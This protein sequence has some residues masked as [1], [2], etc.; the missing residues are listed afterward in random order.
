MNSTA[1]CSTRRGVVSARLYF[2]RDSPCDENKQPHHTGSVA[3]G[4]KKERAF[5]RTPGRRCQ[6]CYWCI[7]KDPWKRQHHQGIWIARTL[8]AAGN[9]QELTH[10]MDRY[11][12][13]ILGLCEMRWNF[14]RSQ[15][16]IYQT[17]WVSC[18]P[19]FSTFQCLPNFFFS[20]VP[21][22]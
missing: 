21:V 22:Q 6:V 7:I 8:R 14:R 17:I 2:A 1:T 15:D 11:R 20:Y 18:L 9:L 3:A 16:F 4:V 19:M 13:N 12:L 10:E 5:H